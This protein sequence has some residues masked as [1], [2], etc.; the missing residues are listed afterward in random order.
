[1]TSRFGFWASL[2]A[3]FFSLAYGVPQILQV[4]GLLADPLD[5]ILIFAP[6]LALAPSFV[7]AMA[8]LHDRAPVGRS[9][10]SLAGLSLAIMYGVMVSI[11]YV[12]QLSAV[13]P[14]D[15]AGDG[16]AT[17]IFACCGQHQPLTG[18][19]LLGYTLMSLATLFAAPAIRASSG[20]GRAARFWLVVN[21]L[22]APFLIAQTAY[23]ALIYVGALWLVT[24]PLAMLF[25]TLVF[26]RPTVPA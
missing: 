22:L 25:L 16:A 26:A 7:L 2:A 20:A 15:L 23:P 1:M 21:G 10:W 6:S 3:L 4:A 17:A 12:I 14:H 5:R 9:V 24:F 18:V 8:A 13:I 19:D 11:V